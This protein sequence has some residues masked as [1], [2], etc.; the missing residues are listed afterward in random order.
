[1]PNDIKIGLL[2]LGAILILVAILGGNF[3]L[4]GAKVGQTISDLRLRFASFFLGAF[5]LVLAV[6]P[7]PVPGPGTPQP[8]PISTP[9]STPT[10]IPEQV[11]LKMSFGERSLIKD[12][13][14]QSGCQETGDQFNGHKRNGTLNMEAASK[15]GTLRSDAEASYKQA[16]NEFDAAYQACKNTPEALIYRENALIGLS[17]AYTIAVPVPIT[18]SGSGQPE[19]GRALM[20]LRGFAQAQEKINK[21]SD[22]VNG[23]PLKLLIVDDEDNKD[24]AARIAEALIG[25]TSVKAV[26]GHWTSDVSESAAK[27]Y[28]GKLVFIT[29]I[30]IFDRLSS[31][32]PWVF[33][34]NATSTIGAEALKNYVNSKPL[35]K[36]SQVLIF[37]D[38][39]IPYSVELKD[40]FYNAI[41]R[42]RVFDDI[43]LR[44]YNLRSNNIIDQATQ[45]ECILA[46]FPGP[47]TV[48]I[49]LGIMQK[50][51]SSSPLL[52]GDMANLYTVKTLGRPGAKGMVM[53]PPWNIDS[54]S[55][56][57]FTTEAKAL[58][59][60][61]DVSWAA[62]MSY[63][64]GQALIQAIKNAGETDNLR[65]GI[66]QALVSD[67]FSVP[68][69]VPSQFSF[70]DQ[71]DAG[72]GVQLV[73]VCSVEQD[74]GERKPKF[75]PIDLDS[76]CEPE[77]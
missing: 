67:S 8:T 62:A 66:Q 57:T 69:G 75:V 51:G 19:R 25:N 31:Y 35:L 11:G 61:N 14:I 73:Q 30:S 33:R 36:D 40:A 15:I 56:S 48:D 6:F 53:A 38:S 50:Y 45:N 5:F 76:Q 20:M 42:R 43:D 68:N 52:L 7:V 26:M 72:M 63:N 2:A 65:L 39:E 3:E 24:T 23:K 71:G 12:E 55:Q 22:K 34:I 44:T 1:M 29:P 74:S 37:F 77:P 21:S 70:S 46:F 59:N 18:E 4:F 17:D 41:T 47:P 58:W 54:D 16:A 60:N 32:V 27:I 13:A 10:S 9:I 64:A 49:A 28:N